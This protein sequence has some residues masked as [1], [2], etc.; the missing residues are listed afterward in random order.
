MAQKHTR[1][2]HRGKPAYG[3][4]A[5]QLTAPKQTSLRHRGKAVYGAVA[6]PAF[7]L[8]SPLYIEKY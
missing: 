4:E 5:T 1:L 3:T 6:K 8:E 2:R 7:D